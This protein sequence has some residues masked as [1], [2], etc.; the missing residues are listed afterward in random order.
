MTEKRAYSYAV[1][2]YV[3]DMVSGEALNVGVVMHAPAA[4]FLKARTR[5][6]VGRLKQAFPDLDPAAFADAMQAVDCG[7][8]TIAKQANGMSLFDARSDARTTCLEGTARR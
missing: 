7:F 1:L 5:K 8:S 6:T 3:H 4:S 2:R